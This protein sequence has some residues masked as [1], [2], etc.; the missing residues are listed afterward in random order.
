MV[1]ENTRFLELA[2]FV[3]ASADLNPEIFFEPI[4][5]SKLPYLCIWQTVRLAF[6]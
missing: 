6:A 1:Q 5:K 2:Y 4:G 3:M